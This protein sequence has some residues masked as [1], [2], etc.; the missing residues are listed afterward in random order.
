MF[1]II[2]HARNWLGQVVLEK[3]TV[4]HPLQHPHVHGAA[5]TVQRQP[6]QVYTGK[7]ASSVDGRPVLGRR[8]DEPRGD[9]V[10]RADHSSIR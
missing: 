10:G 6:H 3:V 7:G 8:E 5:E 9:V 1:F 2:L 4:L